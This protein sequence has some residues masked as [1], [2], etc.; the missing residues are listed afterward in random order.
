MYITLKFLFSPMRKEHETK[1]STPKKELLAI[2]FM[3]K[4]FEKF[5]LGRKFTIFTD[6]KSLL[7]SVKQYSTMS[8]YDYLSQ[9]QF[10]IQHISG[11]ENELPDCLS[12]LYQK[13]LDKEQENCQVNVI[14]IEEEI[15]KIHAMGHYGVNNM[16]KLLKLR[17]IKFKNMKKYC[18]DYIRG[19]SVCQEWSNSIPQ[20]SP[21]NP[22]FSN[23]IWHRIAVDL[24]GP[25]P[26]NDEEFSFLLVLVDVASRYVI[27]EP[28]LDK[29]ALS[30]SSALCK[31]FA[32]FG[33][34]RIIQSDNGTEFD[35]K[36]ISFIKDTFQISDV[37]T[38]PY[39]P[40]QNGVVE[41]QI[42]TVSSILKKITSANL[43][44][45]NE[46]PKAISAVQFAINQRFSK[47]TDFQR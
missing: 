9:F 42:K 36:M 27:V 16:V 40:S 32:L 11:K 41:R 39:T 34:P 44:I 12:R 45:I 7:S 13:D 35:N 25:M 20:F 47:A 38:T 15:E 1:Y 23:G 5:L 29:S 19:C 6:H 10:E 28:I 26:P 4:K 37:Y 30:V 31:I 2:V 18:A 21:I 22:V 24:V 8:W 17:N 14:N 3:I 33:V 43:K 46:W